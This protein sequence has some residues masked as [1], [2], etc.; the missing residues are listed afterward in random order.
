[1]PQK[2]YK[3]EDFLSMNVAIAPQWSF[4]DSQIIYRSDKSGT[5]QLFVMSAEG[6]KE[7]QLTGG[8]KGGQV[9]F[10]FVFGILNKCLAPLALMSVII[11]IMS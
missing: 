8:R 11:S 9:P 3:I 5:M 10:S 6:G 7:I 4:D 2:R 1:M